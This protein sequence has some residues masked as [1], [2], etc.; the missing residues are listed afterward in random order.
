MYLLNFM[1]LIRLSIAGEVECTDTPNWTYTRGTRSYTC[2]HFAASN[3]CGDS[4]CKQTSAGQLCGEHFNNPEKNC[5][6][7]GKQPQPDLENAN[8]S[9]SIEHSLSSISEKTQPERDESNARP[10]SASFIRVPQA[11]ATANTDI[12]E[13]VD[14]IDK[15][16][17][18]ANVEATGVIKAASNNTTK[19]AFA[20][21]VTL[22]SNTEAR[23]AY[24][25]G[26]GTVRKLGRD[27][28][29]LSYALLT[30][31][32]ASVFVYSYYGLWRNQGM[33]YCLGKNQGYRKI[34]TPSRKVLYD[35]DLCAA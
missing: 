5:C 2:V 34:T 6:V 14:A 19:L 16:I 15:V 12:H 13:A 28:L 24:N 33:M 4:E 27:S 30:V 31:I 10:R 3:V 7:C 20:D 25:P 26:T 23:I 22:E 8:D 32:A 18:A 9:T 21:E 29:L 17:E 11:P 1:F 35:P